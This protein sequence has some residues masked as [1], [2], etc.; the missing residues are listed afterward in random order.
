MKGIQIERYN[1]IRELPLYN[2]R[3]LHDNAKY[4]RVILDEQS[5]SPARKNDYK[6]VLQIQ[7]SY[8]LEFGMSEN[9]IELNRL[10]NKLS[11]AK[12]KSQLKGDKIALNDV[13]RLEFQINELKD[14][15]NSQKKADLDAIIIAVEDDRGFE[16]DE[17]KISTLMFLKRYEN[18]KN[19]IEKINAHKNSLNHGR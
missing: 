1:S 7:E 6:A 10:E 8:V 4:C 12:I 11:E 2:W 15:M 17:K 16:I 14:Q 18:L 5:N 9:I 13:R 3:H 19:K